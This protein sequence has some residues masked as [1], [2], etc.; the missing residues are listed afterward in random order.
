MISLRDALVIT[1]TRD[2]DGNKVPFSLKWSTANV[3]RRTGGK[4]IF[5][6]NLTR[7]GLNHSSKNNDTI[8][9]VSERLK[10]PVPVHIHLIMAINGVEVQV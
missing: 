5:E 7:T 1:E 6:E 10:H 9:V 3:T 4:F 2:E 8:G